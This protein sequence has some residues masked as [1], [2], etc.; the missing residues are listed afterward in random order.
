MR[1]ARKH[2][3][4]ELQPCSLCRATIKSVQAQTYQDFEIVVTDDGSVDGTPDLIEAMQEPRLRLHRFPANRGAVIAGNDALRRSRGEYIAILSSDDVFL[5][6]KLERQVAYLDSYPEVGAVFA[7]PTFIDHFGR[8]ISQ[9]QALNGRLFDVEN[10]S[11]VEWLRHFFFL[12]NCLCHPTVLIRRACYEALGL[13]DARFAA[14]PDL[15]MWIRLVAA[16]EIRVM[17]ERL[18]AFRHVPNAGNASSTRVDNFLRFTWENPQVLK[19]YAELPSA[20]FA[21]VFEPEIA[22]LKLDSQ[23]DKRLV[24]GH[25]C[26]ATSNPTLHRLGLDLLFAGLSPGGESAAGFSHADFHRYG[27]GAKDVHNVLSQHKVGQ[28]EA[29]LRDAMALQNATG[30]TATLATEVN[31]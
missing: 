31:P 4:S 18:T 29:R 15:H 2:H 14:L 1:A 5:P 6:H 9:D 26:L 16:Y 12:G 7:Y 19:L 21:A 10:R 11:R 25:I 23:A 20:L 17:P 27:T 30:Q 24:L 13:Y 22:T 28:L 8:N 3:H